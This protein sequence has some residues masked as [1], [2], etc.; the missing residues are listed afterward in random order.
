MT[1]IKESLDHGERAR[2]AAA[3][4]VQMLQAGR[5]WEAEG[6]LS[7]AATERHLSYEKWDTAEVASR[8]LRDCRA[9]ERGTQ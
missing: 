3:R 5:H 9:I 7:Y 4:G 2:F 1:L 8:A 6:S